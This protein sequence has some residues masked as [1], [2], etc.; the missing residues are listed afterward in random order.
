MQRWDTIFAILPVGRKLFTMIQ[1]SNT[2]HQLCHS[3]LTMLLNFVGSHDNDNGTPP[4]VG[5]ELWFPVCLPR[6]DPTGFVY[7]YHHSCRTVDDEYDN[8]GSSEPWSDGTSNCG[9]RRL[10]LDLTLISLQI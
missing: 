2:R 3:D 5:S 8:D 10:R 1:P 6:L 4:S 9:H 7:T